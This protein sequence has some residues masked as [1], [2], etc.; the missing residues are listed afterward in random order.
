MYSKETMTYRFVEYS[1]EY[2]EQISALRSRTFGG[3]LAFNTGYFEW[4]YEQNPYLE[5]PH[6]YLALNGEEVVAM[7]GFYGSRWQVGQWTSVV[8]LDFAP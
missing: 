4:K 6:F 1:P 3:D 7:R 5:E 2:K 8:A